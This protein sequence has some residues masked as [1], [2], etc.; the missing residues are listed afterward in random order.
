VSYSPVVRDG[1]HLAARLLD[2]RLHTGLGVHDGFSALLANGAGADFLW[3]SSFA[4]SAICGLPDAGLLEAS[5][6]APVVDQISRVTDLPLVVDMDAG[7]GD[8]LKVLYS[9]DV[10]TRAGA[11]AICIE[12]NPISKRSSLYDCERELVSPE[13]HCARIKAARAGIAD[14]PCA[15]IARTEALVAGLGVD[16]ALM[17]AAAYVDAGAHAVF[18]QAVAPD[19]QLFEFCTRWGRRTPVFLAPT[20]YPHCTRAHWF[21]AGASHVIFA[22]QGIRAAHGAMLTVFSQLLASDAPIEAEEGIS[23]VADIAEEVGV[24]MA[25]K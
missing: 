18:A 16:E 14:R 3:A 21:F 10:M 19:D 20:A 2:D 6:M 8:D 15:V 24:K 12:D 11:T 1:E 25:L 7:Y 13:V 9:A 5:T 4:A 22:N 23:S 17:R